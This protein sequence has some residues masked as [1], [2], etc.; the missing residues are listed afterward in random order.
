MVKLTDP[1]PPLREQEEGLLTEVPLIE[2]P[3]SVGLKF[4]SVAVISVPGIA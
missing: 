3:E 4:D 2:Q 1:L